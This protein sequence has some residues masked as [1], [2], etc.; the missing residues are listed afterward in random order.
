MSGNVLD[1]RVQKTR[2]LLQDALVDLVSEKGFELV[3]IQEILDRSNVGRSTFYTHFQDKHELLHSCFAELGKLFENHNSW[4]LAGNKNIKDSSEADFILNMFRFVGRNH[5]L[6][7]A[8]LGKQGI[9]IFNHPIYDYLYAYMHEALKPFK[10]RNKQASLQT[11][12][13][14]HYFVSAFIGVLR[15]WVEKDMPCTAEEVDK[16]FKQLSV[17]GFKDVLGWS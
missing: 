6:F 12:M 17:T 2:K 10:S 15:W 5:R 4:L 14:A 13:V 1:R 8:L 16:L 7:K 11:E 3:T 9:A